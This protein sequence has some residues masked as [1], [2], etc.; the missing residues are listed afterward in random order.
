[1]ARPAL[2]VDGARQLRRALK[3]AG[4]NVQDLKDAHREAAELVKRAADPDAPR[5]SGALASST[6]AAGTQAAAIV[7]AGSARVPYAGPIHWGWPARH[8]D[9][10]PWIADAAERTE[11]EW[12]QEYLDHL[13]T[14]INA[15]EGIPGR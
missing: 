12:T 7:R 6:R 8:I 3:Q 2:E 11:P 5:R 13:E 15:I 1:M 14:I 10:Q 9:A 4:I